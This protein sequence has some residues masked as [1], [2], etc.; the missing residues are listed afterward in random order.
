M[1]WKPS[2]R[3]FARSWLPF[4]NIIGHVVPHGESYSIHRFM[5]DKETGYAPSHYFVYQFNPLSKV[6]IDEITETADITKCDFEMEVVSPL[7]YNLSGYDKVGAML[8]FENNRGWWTGSIMDEYD[9]MKLW[10]N[11]FGPTIIQV[12]AGVIASFKWLCN[13]PDKGNKWAEN[14]DTDFI[15]KYASPYMGRFWS[16]FV[17]LNNTHCKDCYKF[18]SFLCDKNDKNVIP[19]TRF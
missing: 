10:K 18:E 4:E 11:R 9:A 13:N 5:R 7:N 6:F 12:A 1:S 19:R 17:D 8:F 3:Y 15:L 14:L 16:D 2:T